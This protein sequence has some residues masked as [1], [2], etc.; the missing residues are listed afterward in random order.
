LKRNL[1]KTKLNDCLVTARRSRDGMLA[2]S[3]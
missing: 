2:A 1:S 3:I